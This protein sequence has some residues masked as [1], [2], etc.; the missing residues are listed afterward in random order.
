MKRA[1][2]R[3]RPSTLVGIALLALMLFPVYWMVNAS[4]QPAGNTLQGGWFPSHPDF[5]GYVTAL[6]D[7]GRNLVTS[8]VVA[9]GSVVLSLGLAAPAA[10]AL[11]QFPLRGTNLVLFGILVTQMV[12]SIVVAN[13]LYGAYNDLGLL[14]SYVGL[15]LADSTAGVPFAI[16][17]LRAFMRSI[18]REIIEAA[19]VDG[20]RRLR[21]FRSVVLPLSTN[22]LITAA[23]F[24]FLFTWSDF[25]FA[26][27]L[28]TT[29]TV[30]PITLGIYQYI[31]AHT[32]QWNAIM[33]TTVMASVP[34]AVLLV[35][36][37]R[38]VATGASSGA[39][40]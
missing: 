20:A 30:R 40:K 14:N 28:T 33:A 27:T 13:A 32:N 39:V 31:G 9:L 15:I 29:E 1:P 23:V 36:A 38:Y 35:V 3:G 17:I 11:A 5:S 26:L 37:Q 16:I 6:R 8:L 18:P 19:R 25:L 4:L 22:A 2:G 7:Q 24:T 21:V 34:A 12:P 10:Y